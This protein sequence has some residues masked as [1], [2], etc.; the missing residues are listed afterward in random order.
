MAGAMAGHSGP[1]LIEGEQLLFRIKRQMVHG[2][3]RKQPLL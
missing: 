2:N 3:G 1:P